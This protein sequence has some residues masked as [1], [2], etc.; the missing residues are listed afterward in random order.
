MQCM[1]HVRLIIEFSYGISNSSFRKHFTRQQ[2]LY[3]ILVSPVLVV[4]LA[5]KRIIYKPE[6]GIVYFYGV[7]G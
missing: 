3:Y 5:I 1:Q 4:P 2:F 7:N 6:K